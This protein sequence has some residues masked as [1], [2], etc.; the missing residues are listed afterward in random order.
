MF[1]SEQ[2]NAIS[3]CDGTG[4]RPLQIACHDRETEFDMFTLLVDRDPSSLHHRDN[5]D[6]QALCVESDAV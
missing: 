1:L 3:V 5:E 4:S 6:S 2:D